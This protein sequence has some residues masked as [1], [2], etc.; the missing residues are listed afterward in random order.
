VTGVEKDEIILLKKTAISEKAE[1]LGEVKQYL[2]QTTAALEKIPLSE[3]WKRKSGSQKRR[4]SAYSK[5]IF[6]LESPRR[7]EKK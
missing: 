3:G 7:K 6:A 4:P 1:R 2:L 5:E